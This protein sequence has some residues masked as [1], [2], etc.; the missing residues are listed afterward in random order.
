MW[1]KSNLFLLGGMLALSAFTS[2]CKK[3]DE[4]SN[5][6]PDPIVPATYA[7]IMLVNENSTMVIDP[8]QEER[9]SVYSGS[10]LLGSLLPT[11]NY[12]SPYISIAEGS[13][14]LTAYTYSNGGADSTA[15]TSASVN[16]ELGKAYSLF[17][18]PDQ[19]P[20]I[21]ST[22]LLL[23]DNLSAPAPGNAHVRFVHLCPDAPAVDFSLLKKVVSK[24]VNG[25]LDN[26]PANKNKAGIV[27]SLTDSVF[28]HSVALVSQGAT[29]ATISLHSND[30]GFAQIK[31]SAG[32][33][34]ISGIS[35]EVVLDWMIPPGTYRLVAESLNGNLATRETG[36]NYPEP[37]SSFGFGQ[38]E[39]SIDSLD[40]TINS[41]P[42]SAY[43]YFYNFNWFADD[44]A[45]LIPNVA[46]KSGS[47]FTPVANNTFVLSLEVAGSNTP[48]L[49]LKDFKL[50]DGK[51]YSVLAKGFLAPAAGE[52]GLNLKV[53]TNK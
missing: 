36:Q 8:A 26:V 50:Q 19:D 34:L 43:N 17:L 53:I 39:G 18:A 32:N 48:V 44:A 35:N 15:V 23:E 1:N 2:S 47:S 14:T 25:T 51:I 45:D 7:Q 52:P 41:A 21:R 5:E 24:G 30:P 33:T 42:N 22:S 6:F 27:F 38:I 13:Q 11:F 37:F 49:Y 46:F 16:V 10:K 29:T 4:I 9:V 40:A 3:E 28:L 12:F 31:T 20:A